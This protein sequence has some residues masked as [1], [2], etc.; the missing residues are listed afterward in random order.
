MGQPVN[1]KKT[2]TTRISLYTSSLEMLIGTFKVQNRNTQIQPVL[3]THNNFYV[4]PISHAEFGTKDR[5]FRAAIQ[6]C[7]PVCF[8]Q[9]K[10][11]V[12]NETSFKQCRWGIENVYFNYETIPEQFSNVLCAFNTQNDTL[13]G[14]HEGFNRSF[15]FPR[16]LLCS[17][18]YI[19][20][21]W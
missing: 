8:N 13:G 21:K 6:N 12:R 17:Y 11:F 15:S 20:C 5:T 1:G 19:K 18:I 9:S 10:Y 7:V 3:G 14:F 16:Y 2:G 4:S